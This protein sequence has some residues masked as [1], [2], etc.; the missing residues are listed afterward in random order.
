MGDVSKPRSHV[1]TSDDYSWE[2]R[3]GVTHNP[4]AKLV[5]SQDGERPEL[6]FYRPIN[7][8]EDERDWERRQTRLQSNSLTS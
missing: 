8:S 2:T 6:L 5:S 7:D 1:I 4:S 3:G